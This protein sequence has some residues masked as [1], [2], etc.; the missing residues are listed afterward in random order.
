[1]ERERKRRH[2]SDSEAEVDSGT[3]DM[4]QDEVNEVLKPPVAKREPKR[5]KPEE[6]VLS[7]T[8]PIALTNEENNQFRQALFALFEE[9]HVQEVI[10]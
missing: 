5:R 8:E 7:D 2:D 1:L 3:E 9:K 6:E 10:R 4:E